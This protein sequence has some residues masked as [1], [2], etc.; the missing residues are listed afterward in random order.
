MAQGLRAYLD[1]SATTKVAEEVLQAMWPYFSERWGNPSSAHSL[2]RDAAEAIEKARAQAAA[3]IQS[4]PRE[5]VFTS[6]GTE[7]INAV[8][9]SAL[10]TQPGKNHIVMTAVEHHAALRCAQSLERRGIAITHI[11]VNADGR[12]DLDQLADAIQPHTALVSVMTANNETGV[13][14]PVAE[15]GAICAARGVPFHTDA[16]QAAGKLPLNVAQTGVT[17]L[18]ISAH[19]FH[20]PKG[21]GAIFIRRFSKFEPYICGGGQE[22]G[23]RSGTEDVP[24]I[25]G[26]GAATVLAEQGHGE[27]NG[28]VRKLRDDLERQILSTIEGVSVNGDQELRLPNIT[29]IAFDGVDSRALLPMLDR[30]GIFASTGAA[31]AAGAMQPSHVL[32]AMGRSIVQARSCLRFSLSHFNTDEDIALLLDVLPKAVRKLRQHCAAQA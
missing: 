8:F 29:N 9:H 25:V 6:G 23:R 11:S 16:V 22:M 28:R 27:M 1:N 4:E 10:S 26:L 32:V 21:A 7:G 31:C 19:K 17:F 13:L 18:T 3:M 20:G 30:D 2:G 14:F 12:L 24:A 15:V 5:I